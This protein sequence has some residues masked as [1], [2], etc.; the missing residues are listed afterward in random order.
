MRPNFLVILCD[1]LGYGDLACY[2]HATVE[3]E[4]LDRLANEGVRATHFYSAAPVCSP[5]RVGLLTGRI[6][7]RLGVYDW[8]PPAGPEPSKR[9]DNRHLVH[10]RRGEPT[11]ASLLRGAGYATCIAGK[12]HCNSRFNHASQPQPS[13]AG[14]DHWFATS[15]NANPSHE[16]PT[17][18]VRNGEEVGPI[19]GFSCQ[20][21]ADEAIGWIKRQRRGTPDKPFF[22]YVPFHE[23]HEPVASPAPLVEKYLPRSKN[24]DQAQYFANV[25]NVD[26]ATGRLL[27]ALDELGLRDNTLVVFTSDNGP[28]TLKRY[29]RAHRSYGSPGPLRGMKLWTTEAGCRVPGIF[30]WPG[31]LPAGTEPRAV[32][33]ALDLLPTFCRLAGVAPPANVGLDGVDCLPMLTGKTA[34][35]GEPLLWC[36]YN[37]TNGRRVA[38]RVGEWK[39][40]ARLASA[41]AVGKR[42]PKLSNVHPGN[43]ALATQAQLIDHKLFRVT[44]DPAER[45]DLSADFPD[46]LDRLKLL[47]AESYAELAADSPVWRE[48]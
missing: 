45:R 28:E 21:V 42:L 12:W 35:R 19:E 13:D 30:R 16:N 40:L 4:R 15:N 31:V 48:E 20:L 23:T 22:L 3:T 11:I 2:G 6:P 17:N 29:R 18:F 27:D 33:S 14:F 9:G 8:I 26:L 39:V 47:L 25:H 44:D 43:Y 37:A 5:S 38:M 41:E 36:Y 32:I 34:E 1:D 46:E 24:R 7:N 10:L